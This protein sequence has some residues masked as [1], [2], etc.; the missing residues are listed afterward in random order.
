MDNRLKKF[1][2]D[3]SKHNALL[4]DSAKQR[5]RENIFSKLNHATEEVAVFSFFGR[6][7]SILGKSYIVAPL[8]FLLFIAGTTIVSADAA[9]GDKLYSVKRQVEKARL[10][11]APTESA[12]LDLQVD[13]AEKRLLE[14]EKIEEK[15]ET[16]P[17]QDEV[18][19]DKA[20]SEDVSKTK[21]M[22][23]KARVQA[24]NAKKFLNEA[25]ENLENRGHSEQKVRQINERIN[26]LLEQTKSKNK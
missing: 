22:E 20:E 3:N 23:T 9:P 6:I 24:E 16:Q 25:K 14:L 18:K 21:A 17:E 19:E 7:S 10:F 1:Y 8:V 5:V 12:K 15:S 4:S 11:I 13:F 2:N 26:K